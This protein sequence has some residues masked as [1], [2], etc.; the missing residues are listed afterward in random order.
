MACNKNHS[1]VQSIMNT[2]PVD[3]GGKGR[4]KCAACAYELGYNAGNNLDEEINLGDLLNSLD[5]SQAQAQRQK[6]HTPLMQK[7]ILMALSIVLTAAW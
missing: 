4:H 3:Q 7:V 1:G 2:L 6:V 5:E